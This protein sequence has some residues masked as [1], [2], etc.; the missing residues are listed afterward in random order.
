MSV[1]Y[2]HRLRARVINVVCGLRVENALGG[3]I[4]GASVFA[5]EKKSSPDGDMMPWN[6]K[7]MVRHSAFPTE[8]NAHV[9]FDKPRLSRK[10][11]VPHRH[12]SSP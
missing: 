7:R 8:W 1:V 2:L 5:G 9:Y 10:G 3:G 6:G 11:R 12:H 4:D